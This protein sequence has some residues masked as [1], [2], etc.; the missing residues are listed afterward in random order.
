MLGADRCLVTLLALMD[1]A[2]V[3][4]MVDLHEGICVPLIT[5]FSKLLFSQLSIDLCKMLWVLLLFDG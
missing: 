4:G 5:V 2:V 1:M 3:G